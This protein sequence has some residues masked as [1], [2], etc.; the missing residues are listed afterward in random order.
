MENLPKLN[1]VFRQEKEVPQ[2]VG[3][4][5]FDIY[6]VDEIKITKGEPMIATV[7]LE[8]QQDEGKYFDEHYFLVGRI[9]PVD[10][11][12]AFPWEYRLLSPGKL[13][14]SCQSGKIATYITPVGKCYV[15]EYDNRTHVFEKSGDMVAAT[16]D[17]VSSCLEIRNQFVSDNKQI[18]KAKREN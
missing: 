15:R 9:E 7:I 17:F 12:L 5:Y 11:V 13:V 16:L 1:V 10:R 14:E 6:D 8:Y 2:I 18:C 3:D 4:M